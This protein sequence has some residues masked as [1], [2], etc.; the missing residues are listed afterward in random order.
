M[1]KER[2]VQALEAKALDDRMQKL[3]MKQKVKEHHQK[4]IRFDN[5]CYTNK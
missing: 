5:F 1:L 3:N 2:K 4:Q